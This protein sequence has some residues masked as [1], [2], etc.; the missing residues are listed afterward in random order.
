M[1]ATESIMNVAYASAI[2]SLFMW[3]CGTV[4]LYVRGRSM[5]SVN[6]EDGSMMRFFNRIFFVPAKK[7]N[8]L[9][10][11]GEK[12]ALV[13]RWVRIGDN[14]TA[15]I[16]ISLLVFF[17]AA[18]LESMNAEF[19]VPLVWF[20]VA[21]RACHT[22]FYAAAIQPLRTVAYVASSTSMAIA[23]VSILLV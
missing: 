13:N 4:T 8:V 22:V 12:D 1:Q 19:L 2:L 7:L 18:W 20:F 11:N 3:Q 9:P 10:D 16:P 21:A 17:V 6:G 23:A 14:N 5:E 15:N